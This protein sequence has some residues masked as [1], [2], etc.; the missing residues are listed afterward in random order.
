V[1]AFFC[2][3]RVDV[4]GGVNISTLAAADFNDAAKLISRTTA[5]GGYIFNL[6][7]T[8]IPTGTYRLGFTVDA[9][10]AVYSV[11]FAVRK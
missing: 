2:A 9:D 5:G 1:A 8:G 6:K 11:Q 3:Y 10:P 4:I 7:T